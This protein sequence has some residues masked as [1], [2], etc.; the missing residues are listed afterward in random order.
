VTLRTKAEG[1][2]TFIALHPEWRKQFVKYDVGDTGPFS[3]EKAQLLAMVVTEGYADRTSFG[4]ANTQELLHADFGRMGSRVY[5]DV[6]IGRN[7]L[8]SRVS[9]VMIAQELSRLMPAKAFR[10]DVL[11][12]I[13]GSPSAV[14]KVLRIIA[15]TEG[16]MLISIRKAS[17][18]FTVEPRIVLASSNPAFTEQIQ[19]LLDSLGIETHISK[20]GIIINKK[21]QIASFIEMVGFSLGVKVVRK[22]AGYSIWYGSEKAGLQKL[23]YRVMDEQKR[24]RSSGL[25]GCFADCTFREQ[26]LRRLGGWYAEENGGGVN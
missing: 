23:F 15:D 22:R 9:S 26:T 5:G 19:V 3:E 21:S 17:R 12:F 2:K 18:N 6:T 8:T 7:R 24:A 11:G 20:I 4:F 14:K 13:L 10:G 1:T 25:R 16:A